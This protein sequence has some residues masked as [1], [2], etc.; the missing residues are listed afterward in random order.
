[1]SGA[2]VLDA[3]LSLLWAWWPLLLPMIP[4]SILAINLLWWRP[5]R[6]SQGVKQGAGAQ[7]LSAQRGA[8]PIRVSMLVP[9]RDEARQIADCLTALQ[10]AVPADGSIQAEILVYDDG[11]TDGTGEIV[12]RLRRPLADRPDLA[13]LPPIRLMRGGSLPEGWAGKPHACQRL[14][15]AATGDILIFCDADVRLQPGA[16]AAMVEALTDIK[17]PA[18][19]LT[20]LPLQRMPTA[21]EGWLLPLL[22]VAL[23]CWL[24]LPLMDLTY[25]HRFCAACGQVVAIRRD[26]W[27]RLGGYAAIR[28]S[29]IED[30]ALVRAARR[31]RMRARFCDGSEIATCRMYEDLPGIWAG[32]SKNI[33]PGLGPINLLVALSL[34]LGCFVAPILALPARPLAA[35]GGTA[36]ILATRALLSLRFKQPLWS[37]PLHPL[38][39]LALC[40]IA[41]NSARWSLLGMIRWRG[42]VYAA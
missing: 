11:S 8:T 40:G 19:L 15:E 33:Y 23:L 22:H 2:E 17:R 30:V 6:P 34:Y 24:P 38:A 35:I 3:A 29:V 20:L 31:A 39:V 9:A 21:A 14:A 10:H 1:M 27:D 5:L 41:L 32:F 28:G 4:L 18:E 7:G 25:Y 16:V 12:E 13:P 26:A 42:R 36:A 37:A